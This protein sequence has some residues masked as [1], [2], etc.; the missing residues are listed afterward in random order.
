MPQTQVPLD[1]TGDPVLRD[2]PGFGCTLRDG[3][4]DAAWV[5]VVGELDV[6]TAPLLEHTLRRAE[7]WPRLVLDLREL[8]F[9][10]CGGMSVIIRAGNRATERGRRL[11]LVRGPAHVDRVLTLTGASDVLEVVDLLPVQ[12]PVQALVQ[13]AHQ[14]CAA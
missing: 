6:A 1:S 4:V 7:I 13:L 8:A 9:M 12:P 10:D 5:H 2:A 11:V 3:G 14:N